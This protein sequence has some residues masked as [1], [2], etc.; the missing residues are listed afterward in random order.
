MLGTPP[1]SL[2]HRSRRPV[3][4]L[5]SAGGTG[6]GALL[7]LAMAGECWCNNRR[8]IWGYGSIPNVGLVGDSKKSGETD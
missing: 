8:E 1:P 2:G 5:Q 3:E 6:A 7:L 4:Q